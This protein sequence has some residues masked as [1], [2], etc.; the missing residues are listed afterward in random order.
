MPLVPYQCKRCKTKQTRNVT[1][2]NPS[3]F[4]KKP[5]MLIVCWC[6]DTQCG[7]S[8]G[9]NIRFEDNNK[10]S[11]ISYEATEYL[12]DTSKDEQVITARPRV[13]N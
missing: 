4:S 11:L 9:L 12:Y 3:S 8:I 2:I 7:T 6:V 13:K 5:E 1:W 10:V